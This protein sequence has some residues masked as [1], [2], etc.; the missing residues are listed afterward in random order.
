MK[1]NALDSAI[2]AYGSK[3]SAAVDTQDWAQ[4]ENTLVRLVYVLTPLDP[5]GETSRVF[6]MKAASDDARLLKKVAANHRQP[7]TSELCF[8]VGV[9][10]SCF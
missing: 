2:N 1:L 9:M 8:L 10:V 3:R 5:S 6:L 7:L 4:D